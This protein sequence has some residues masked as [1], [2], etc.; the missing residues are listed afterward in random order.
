M[1]CDAVS[2]HVHESLFPHYA[3][4]YALEDRLLSVA[5]Q[6]LSCLSPADH[7][8][9]PFL[10]LDGCERVEDGKVKGGGYDQAVGRCRAAEGLPEWSDPMDLPD[11]ETDPL[12]EGET[13]AARKGRQRQHKGA[14]REQG[15][16][17][18]RGKLINVPA[19]RVP[20]SLRT[21]LARNAQGSYCRAIDY[22]GLLQV[23]RTPSDKRLLFSQAMDA[24]ALSSKDYYRHRYPSPGDGG[25]GSGSQVDLSTLAIGADEQT[26]LTLF[27]M[28]SSRVP[29]LHSHLCYVSDCFD[30][31]EKN[32]GY[33]GAAGREDFCFT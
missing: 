21:E 4:R 20:T 27:V 6:V 31:V 22:L 1:V 16:R 17:V 11:G 7:G 5:S 10:R 12:Y 2:A 28:C 19:I 3:A 13:E 24:M 14:L 18:K 15:A 8:V 9:P 23:A 29:F 26:P 25:H 32:G 30:Y 33:T